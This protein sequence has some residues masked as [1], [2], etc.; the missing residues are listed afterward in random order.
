MDLNQHIILDQ[1]E[2]D[3]KEE[4]KQIA[5]LLRG[6]RFA[7]IFYESN[8]AGQP[9]WK[10]KEAQSRID[11]IWIDCYWKQS[12]LVCKTKDMKLRTGSDYQ[13]VLVQQEMGLN[14]WKR[15]QAKN[16]EI[17]RKRLEID[18]E[19]TNE[20]N[21]EEYQAE[22]NKEIKRKLSKN[23]EKGSIQSNI[24]DH[25]TLKNKTSDE[26]W[27]IIEYSIKKLAANKLSQKKKTSVVE[28]I[29]YTDTENKKLRK[30][31]RTLGKWYRKLKKNKEREITVQEVKE[32]H[33]IEEINSKWYESLI[34]EV[35]E[36]EW[37]EA[38]EQTKSKLAS[39]MSGITYPMIKKANGYAKE[40]F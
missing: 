28:E 11:T 4:K 10:H 26:L 15:S 8:S 5:Q 38:L 1:N 18:I 24:L 30:D 21:W 19:S 29:S 33:P 39:S 35:T 14:L 32:L 9:T 22:L 3:G 31:I 13:A 27:D 20:K 2:Q 17:R 40:I 34:K 37:E 12:V 6:K 7:D 36:E 23:I 25:Y 16:R